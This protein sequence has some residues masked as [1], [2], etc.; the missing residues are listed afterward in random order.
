MSKG[1][2]ITFSVNPDSYGIGVENEKFKAYIGMK[3]AR[4]EESDTEEPA[5][6]KL[7][8]YKRPNQTQKRYKK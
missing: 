2:H 4:K 5:R 8:P 6:K 1:I 7:R 3:H